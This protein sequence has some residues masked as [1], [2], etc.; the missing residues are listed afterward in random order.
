MD[1]FY[2]NICMDMKEIV[3]LLNEIWSIMVVEIEVD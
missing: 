3:I 1:F 2:N